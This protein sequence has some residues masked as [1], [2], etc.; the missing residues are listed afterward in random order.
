MTNNQHEQV[1]EA[2]R[3][4]DELEIPIEGYPEATE[5]ERNAAAELRRLHAAVDGLRANATE[6]YLKGHEGVAAHIHALH[7]R[8]AELADKVE[9]LQGLA[10]TCYAGLGAECNLPENWLDALNA[11][12]NGEPFTTSGLLPYKAQPSHTPQADSQPA[13]QRDTGYPPLPECDA[14]TVGLGAVWNRHSMRAYVDAD[15]KARAQADSQSVLDRARIRE[16]FMAHGFT[17]KEGQTDLKQYVYDAADALL[18]AARAPADSVTA[19]AGDQL[20]C[21][22]PC[23]IT[24]GGVTI[25]KGCPLRT[26]QTR[27]KVQS[28]ANALLLRRL[29]ATPPTAQAEGWRSIST[30][31]KDGTRILVHPAIEVADAWSKAHWSAQNECWIVGGSPSGVL[32]TA[33]HP[34]PPPPTSAE[35]VEH[36]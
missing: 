3:L 35:G 26:V 28:E 6:Q 15:R 4:A 16:I 29:I 11:A 23:D 32:H 17:V 7:A 14:T 36:G 25:G 18:R 2:L 10:A 30:A 27:L 34:L 31:P 1:P 33:W 22:L 21:P 24:A 9:A 8:S 13:H 5:L 20:D 12:A 19:P